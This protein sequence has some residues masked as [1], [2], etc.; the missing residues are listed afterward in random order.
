MHGPL[1]LLD[2]T[3]GLDEASLTLTQLPVPRPLTVRPSSIAGA[4]LGV[5]TNQLIPKGV[6]VGPY[7]GRIVDKYDL[8]DL[9]DT[10]YAWEVSHATR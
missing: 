2:T 10:A 4:G 6:R 5:F 8:G 9:Q 7:Q 3:T 1:K